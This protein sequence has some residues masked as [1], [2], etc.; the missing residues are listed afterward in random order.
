LSNRRNNFDAPH[1]N[2]GTAPADAIRRKDSHEHE[3]RERS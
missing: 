3:R 1:P 2:A